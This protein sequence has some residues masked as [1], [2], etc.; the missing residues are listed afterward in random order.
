[1]VCVLLSVNTFTDFYLVCACHASDKEGP[2]VTSFKLH[3]YPG[4]AQLGLWCAAEYL[5]NWDFFSNNLFVLVKRNKRAAA[6]LTLAC[7]TCKPKCNEILKTPFSGQNYCS[8][9][10][11]KETNPCSL[12]SFQSIAHAKW[13]S[14]YT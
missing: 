11:V 8:A 9:V 13:G 1:M 14:N 5:S 6:G 7:V 10:P 4:M 12:G 3:L 2:T